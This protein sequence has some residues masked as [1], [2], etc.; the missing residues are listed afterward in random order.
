MEH[1]ALAN[2][3]RIAR[4]NL[5]RDV[6]AYRTDPVAL[7]QEY[8]CHRLLEKVTVHDY[9]TW[10]PYVGKKKAVRIVGGIVDSSTLKMKD[11]SPVTRE[12]LAKA[13]SGYLARYN[14]NRQDRGLA[15]VGYV[16]SPPLV[17]VAVTA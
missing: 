3:V 13:L 14:N 10:V 15:R 5:K 1:L 16:A 7:L 11:L 17:S 2:E 8:P 9:I 12:N 6:K 4:A